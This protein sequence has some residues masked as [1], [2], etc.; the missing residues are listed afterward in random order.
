MKKNTWRLVVAL[1]TAVHPTVFADEVHL[2]DKFRVYIESYY[3]HNKN[4]EEKLFSDLLGTGQTDV[5]TVK[6]NLHLALKYWAVNRNLALQYF[7]IADSEA[8]RLEN[9]ALVSSVTQY[10][11][12]LY[13]AKYYLDLGEHARAFSITSTLLDSKIAVSDE[14]RYQVWKV[15]IP[16][17]IHEVQGPKL[18]SYFT[19]FTSKYSYSVRTDE[20]YLKIAEACKLINHSAFVELLEVMVAQYPLTSGSTWALDNLV[21]VA[22]S[23]TYKFNFNL[24]K[25][26]SFYDSEDQLLQKQLDHIIQANLFTFATSTMNN[27]SLKKVFAYY[28][29]RN[30]ERAI[31]ESRKVSLAN[32]SADD[33]K[34]LVRTLAYLYSQTDRNYEA[35]HYFEQFGENFS[36]R[37]AD[38]LENYGRHLFRNEKYAEAAQKF[39]NAAS[40][41]KRS[42]L[43]WLHFWSTYRSGD[44]NASLA[45]LEN[46]N[47]VQPLDA[48]YP[49]AKEYWKG[50]ILDRM[51]RHDEANQIFKSI[52]SERRSDFYST[53]I[54]TKYPDLAQLYAPAQRLI[55]ANF[56]SD[57]IMEITNPGL[58][59]E[60]PTVSDEQIPDRIGSLEYPLMYQEEVETLAEAAGLDPFLIYSVIKAESSFNVNAYSSVGATG[61]MQIMPYTGLKI[62][63][64][65]G[66]EFSP[67]Q[68]KDPQVSLAYGIYY[69]K[70]LTDYFDGNFALALAAYNAGPDSVKAWVR[71][72]SGCSTDEFVESITFK[73]TRL[74]V[75]KIYSFYTRYSEIYDS[76]HQPKV[77][78]KIMPERFGKFEIF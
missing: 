63:N 4:S 44:M 10:L 46:K 54:T 67:L 76:T 40:M 77:Y 16:S 39:Q 15:A 55:A 75:K 19:N 18:I 51:G 62:A 8:K 41:S 22:D 29:L 3:E 30:Y 56:Q 47:Y 23:G 78:D 17:A 73:E 20:T 31:D 53:L 21:K 68:L 2:E 64:L 13:R 50:R 49:Q 26:L 42:Y 12:D 43:T 65:L 5:D 58:E 66:Q 9:P 6:S 70:K 59:V 36:W 45:M 71:S 27:S 14:I 38:Y 74:Y 25:K 57:E 72:C 32:L 1:I 37:N 33:H 7:A 34:K 24:L 69:L 48:R 28:H 60:T 52:L 61:L 11:L 35:V